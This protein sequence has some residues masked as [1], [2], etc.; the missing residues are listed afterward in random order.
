MFLFMYQS[1]T[2]SQQCRSGGGSEWKGHPAKTH[3]IVCEKMMEGEGE[4]TAHSP[5]HSKRCQGQFCT[6][7][8]LRQNSKTSSYN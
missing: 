5:T 8:Q 2:V 4:E 6:I 3:N 1:L 7:T